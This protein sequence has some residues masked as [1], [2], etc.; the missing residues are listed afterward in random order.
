MK[1]LLLVAITF[2]TLT[3]ATTTQRQPL[4]KEL[5]DGGGGEPPCPITVCADPKLQN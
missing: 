5:K 1:K 3:S 2:V 4:S